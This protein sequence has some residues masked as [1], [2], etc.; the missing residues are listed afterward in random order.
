[1][2][3]QRGVGIFATVAAVAV[4]AAVS[5]HA[6]PTRPSRASAG[7]SVVN[8]SYSCRV[9]A[10]HYI[11]LDTSVTLP[12]SQDQPRPATLSLFT[13][14]KT[15]KRNGLDFNVPQVFFQA[16]KASLRIDRST[17]VRSSRRIPLKPAG[18]PG[19]QTVTPA[20]LGSL[21]ERCV[22][23]KRVLIHLRVTMQNGTPTSALVAVRNDT[24][25]RLAVEFLNCKPRK[26][27]GYFSKSCVSLN[28]G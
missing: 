17:C 19:P 25:T 21:D 11:D 26:I 14:E 12:P 16:A 22:T 28:S 20:Y 7:S 3:Y 10:Q 24:R 5:A 23:T 6:G 27:K 4:T 1:M 2:R 18:L 15:I 9:R 13:V 8:S